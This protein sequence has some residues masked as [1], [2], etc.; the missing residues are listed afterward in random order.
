L[1]DATAPQLIDDLAVD[2]NN[3]NAW[4]SGHTGGANF[5]MG[6]GSVRLDDGL[7]LPAVQDDGLLLPAVKT[8]GGEATIPDGTSNTVLFG[9]RYG[10][11][12]GEYV[13]TAVQHVSQP[14]ASVPEKGDEVLIGFEFGDVNVGEDSRGLFQINV[15]PAQPDV[16]TFDCSELTQ[17][18]SGTP[19]EGG[20]PKGDW[21]TD[22]TY[23]PAGLLGQPTVATETVTIAHEGFWLT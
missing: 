11:P 6:D 7:L 21:I 17:W 15:D 4:S 8:D 9:E 23:E 2:P 1:V 3:P 20:V 16:D 18:A 14:E 12:D 19:Q 22:V 13:L 5:A 10:S